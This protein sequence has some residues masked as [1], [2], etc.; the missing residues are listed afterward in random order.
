M[1]PSCAFVP[2][3]L[4]VDPPAFPLYNVPMAITNVTV[5][6]S[7]SSAIPPVYFDAAWELGRALVANRWTLVYGGN[8][9]GLMGAVADSVRAAGGRVIGITPQVLVDKGITDQHCD[10]LIV[11]P[12]MRERKA[13]L[14]SRADAFIALPGGLGTLEEIF[15]IIVGRVLATHAKPVILLNIAGYYNP[16]L[17]MIDHGIEHRFIRP[18]QRR[19][20]DLCD[21]V[22]EAMKRLQEYHTPPPLGVDIAIRTIA[23]A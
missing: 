14:E 13:L 19:T 23:E 20:F 9:V 5:Y 8:A 16:L 12:T 11:T 3:S 22:A 4:R 17:A 2:S 1:P 21:T 15:E 18:D 7:S 6:C 10:E